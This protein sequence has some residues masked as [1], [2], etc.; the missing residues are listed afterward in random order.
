MRMFAGLDIGFKRT[1]VCVIE[2]RA[3]SFRRGCGRGAKEALFAAAMAGVAYL[4]AF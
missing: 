4:Q 1:A 3:R 2:E